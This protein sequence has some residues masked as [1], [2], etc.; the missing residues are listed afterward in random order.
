MAANGYPLAMAV[1]AAA[2]AVFVWLHARRADGGGALPA[3]TVRIISVCAAAVAVFTIA[4][5]PPWRDALAGAFG[6]GPGMVFLVLGA[7]VVGAAAIIDWVRHHHAVRTTG[8]V[9]FAATCGAMA[10]AMA[11]E[12]K[13]QGAKLGPK[14][15][16][17]M[18]QAMHQIQDGH[19]AAAETSSAR[20]AVIF[21]AIVA[22]IVLF[23][24][25]HKH[26]KA[27]PFAS[28]RAFGELA[29]GSG[30]RRAI[31]SG[32]QRGKGIFSRLFGRS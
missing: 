11:P 17:A 13:H 30:D 19:A 7:F 2:L 20:A 28:S 22:F 23:A 29:A 31:G 4:G 1:I 18:G 15:A 26:H 24:V 3:G 14:T 27:R 16:A 9:T 6:S 21:L 10:W 12:L 5:I 25:M 8:L 32:R